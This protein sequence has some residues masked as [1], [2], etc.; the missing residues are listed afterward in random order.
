MLIDAIKSSTQSLEYRINLV[1]KHFYWSYQ[2]HFVGKSDT[3]FVNMKEDVH[4]L[5]FP[6]QKTRNSY[7]FR[8]VRNCDGL[9]ICSVSGVSFYVI[10]RIFVV[11]VYLMFPSILF[12]TVCSEP[13]CKR[14]IFVLNQNGNNQSWFVI[15]FNVQCAWLNVISV[16]CHVEMFEIHR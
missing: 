1:V 10:R 8:A 16:R 3:L 6:F 12:L 7:P 15:L 5:E 14:S 9:G 4:H 13:N 11:P 2:L